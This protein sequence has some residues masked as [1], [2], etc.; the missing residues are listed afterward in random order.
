VK[1]PTGSVCS[2]LNRLTVGGGTLIGDTLTDTN[3]ET[4]VAAEA[5]SGEYEISVER[6]WGRPLG[7]KAQ[8]MITLHQ[9]T[10]QETTQIETIDLKVGNTVTAKLEDGRRKTA[11]AVPPPESIK[12]PVVKLEQGLDRVFNQLRDMADPMVTGTEG[13]LRGGLSA[14]GA[15]LSRDL[16]PTARREDKDLGPDRMFLQNPVSSMVDNSMD[17]TAR[18]TLSADRSRI[19]LSMSPV[20]GALNGPTTVPVVHTPVIPG[21]DTNP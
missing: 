6:R 8:V 17:F 12:R 9:G 11:A 18:V 2:C 1:E 15:A 10:P 21:G 7:D 16:R 19:R 4:Y 14:F 13:G 3:S 20:A 5:F